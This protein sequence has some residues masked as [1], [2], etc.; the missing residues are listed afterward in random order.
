M[1]RG[2]TR[3]KQVLT[4]DIYSY[5]PVD[6]SSV[7]QIN[8]EKSIN[9]F[10]PYLGKF[11]QVVPKLKASVNYPLSFVQKNS[12]LYMLGRVTKDRQKKIRELLSS[13]IFPHYPPKIN[14]YKGVEILFYLTEN[15]DFFVC[16]FYK[17]I[18]AG[19]YDLQLL[20]DIID[21]YS[22]QRPA[23]TKTSVGQ[24]SIKQLRT[25]YPANL[26]MNNNGS[27]SVFNID[28]E[29]EEIKM[30]GKDMSIFADEWLCDEHDSDYLE[31]DFP[32][33]PNRLIAYEVNWK[34]SLISD[35][36]K[37]YFSAPSYTF[38]IEEG[39]QPIYALK[40]I[41]D[42]YSI[43]N[44]LNQL[45]EQY[46][47]KRFNIHDY[48]Y[49]YRIYTTSDKMAREVFRTQGSIYMTFINDCLVFSKDRK[50]LESYLIDNGSFLSP[51]N[52]FDYMDLD[53]EIISLFYTKN[54][55]KKSSEFFNA[56]NPLVHNNE[57]YIFSSLKNKKR[58]VEVHLMK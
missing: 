51:D 25:H 1:F 38:Y 8:N 45:E 52:P 58:E 50:S 27:F 57:A 43:Y 35:S 46:I 39:L 56:D 14:T 18:F 48:S 29:E 30:K 2:L 26:F 41:G 32:V 10:L 40:H 49:G 11:D 23:I 5:I 20:E 31:V 22:A 17:D 54:L 28:I 7:L 12:S 42:K 9:L 36:L 44:T 53:S 15:N 33:F 4:T 55:E 47:Q 24:E 13:E 3:N 37:C 34:N 16:M 6:I 21:I 19:G